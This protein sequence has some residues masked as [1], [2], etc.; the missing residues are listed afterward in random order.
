MSFGV[1][2]LKVQESVGRVCQ[3]RTTTMGRRDM[4]LLLL[5]KGRGL[6][7]YFLDCPTAFQVL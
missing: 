6:V 2:L 7:I 3:K 5:A 1:N 4:D